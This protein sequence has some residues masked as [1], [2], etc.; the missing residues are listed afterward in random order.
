MTWIEHDRAMSDPRFRAL[1]IARVEVDEGTGMTHPYFV[2]EGACP[3]LDADR[4]RCTVHPDWFY[5]C[6]TWPFLLMPDGTLMVNMSC[7]GFGEGPKVD[8]EDMRRRILRER[9]RAGMVA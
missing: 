4:N 7:S 6:A 8:P 5:T 3:L 1:S 9:A 2:I